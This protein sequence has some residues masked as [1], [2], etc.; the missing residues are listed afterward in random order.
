MMDQ[1]M[2]FIRLGGPVMYVLTGIGIL[3]IYL[4]LYQ[5]VWLL[6]WRMAQERYSCGGAPYWS[7]RAISM[8]KSKQGLN[9][10]SLLESIDICLN[11]FEDC[12]TRRV[13]TMRF[14]A[15][16]S[17]LLGF[18]GTVTGMVKVFNTV[19]RK[20]T[21][22][23]VDLAGGIYEALFTTVYGLV[24]ALV[25]WGFSHLIESLSRQHGRRIEM[26]IISELEH[27]PAVAEALKTSI[28]KNQRLES[29][30]IS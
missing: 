16:I 4:G 29:G 2:E 9:G 22:A 20:G 1:F 7:K 21:A 6:I 18:L 8:A 17:T 25:A 5:V 3:T 13:P 19:A 11:R 28:E 12:L 26:L 30:S 27:D 23:P 14:L 10:L 24:L 15:Q